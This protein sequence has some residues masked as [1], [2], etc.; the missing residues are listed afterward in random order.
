MP[1]CVAAYVAVIGCVGKLADA[2]TIEHYPDDALKWAIPLPHDALRSG[3]KLSL[4]ED[5][6]PRNAREHSSIAGGWRTARRR[7]HHR[8]EIFV[9]RNN[10]ERGSRM[11]A[12][13]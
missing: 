9:E 3:R 1:E 4:V 5:C 8:C 10:P 2:Y 11:P 6:T 12:L 7:V 13:E